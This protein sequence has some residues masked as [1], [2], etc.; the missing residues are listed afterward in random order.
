MTQRGTRR[1]VASSRRHSLVNIPIRW[2]AAVGCLACLYGT[3]C[4]RQEK[5][6]VRPPDQVRAEIQKV[7]KDP[8]MPPRVKAMVLGLLKQELA[9]S[10][11]AAKGAK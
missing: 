1:A 2:L 7:E 8:K 6:Q 11:Q 9:R 4:S 10:E 5:P 3:A